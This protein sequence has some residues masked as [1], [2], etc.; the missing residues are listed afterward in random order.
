MVTSHF[1]VLIYVLL[2]ENKLCNSSEEAQSLY[3]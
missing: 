2:T 1:Y 3:G